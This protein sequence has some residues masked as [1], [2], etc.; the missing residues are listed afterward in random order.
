MSKNLPYWFIREGEKLIQCS[1]ADFDQAVREGKSVKYRTY[2]NKRAERTADLLEESRMRLL[3][4]PQIPTKFRQTLTD[5]VK[6]VQVQ[7]IDVADPEFWNKEARNPKY[8]TF[9]N[10]NK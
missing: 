3:N 9:L 2:A 7:V 5:P 6:V 10:E 8:Q 1:K 4:N